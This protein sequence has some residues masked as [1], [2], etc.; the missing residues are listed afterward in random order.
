[1]E[2]KAN[3]AYSSKDSVT[4]GA[5]FFLIMRTLRSGEGQIKESKSLVGVAVGCQGSFARDDE[6]Y[7]DIWV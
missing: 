3:L 1:M 6:I 5:P 7:L 4:K 2:G